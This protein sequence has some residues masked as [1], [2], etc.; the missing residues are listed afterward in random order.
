MLRIRP[1][2]ESFA[3]ASLPRRRTVGGIPAD[4]ILLLCLKNSN[5]TKIKWG[6]DHEDI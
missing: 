1:I 4:T 5:A 2:L 3:I 6:E